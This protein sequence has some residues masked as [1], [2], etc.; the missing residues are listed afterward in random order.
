[1]CRTENREDIWRFLLA[2]GSNMCGAAVK[3]QMVEHEITRC[4]QIL[5]LDV[6]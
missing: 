6:I 1:M 3:C 4:H 5:K 2:G